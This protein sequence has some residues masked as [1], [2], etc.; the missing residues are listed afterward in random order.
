MTNSSVIL[1]AGGTG[2][3]GTRMAEILRKKGYQIRM[4]TRS[5]KGEN[6]YFWNP[7]AGEIDLKALEGVHAIVNLA[8]AGIAEGRWT[9]ARK[10]LL[11]E[12]RVQCANVLAKAIVSMPEKPKVYLSASAIGFYGNSG[13][14]WMSENAA[15]VDDSFMVDC[16]QQW[17]T[18]AAQMESLG[19]RTAIFRIG[20]VMTKEGGAL[21]EIL[22]PLKLGIGGYFGDGQA[23]WSWIHRE[24]VCGAFIWGIEQDTISGIFNLVAP[25]PVRGKNLVQTLV[26]VRKMPALVLPVPAFALQLALGEMSAVVLNSNRVSAQKLLDAGFKFQFPTLDAAFQD[27]FAR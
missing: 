27:I 8:G 25:T 15:P 12:S 4:L 7:V 14:A 16:C 24:D 20:V 22:R 11:I 10:K 2:L 6:D 23:W 3:I 26:K 5:P 9:D 19:L 13:E 1:L 17:E 21:A 18:A